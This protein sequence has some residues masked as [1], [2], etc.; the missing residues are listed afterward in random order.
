MEHNDIPCSIELKSVA[1]T[2]MQ[3]QKSAT[4]FLT[5][6]MCFH[7]IARVTYFTLGKE[8]K[9]KVALKCLIMNVSRKIRKFWMSCFMYTILR[10]LSK[11]NRLIVYKYC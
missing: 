9:F 4:L 3:G 2:Q 11:R 7:F 8:N 5:A 1:V 6:S 10:A